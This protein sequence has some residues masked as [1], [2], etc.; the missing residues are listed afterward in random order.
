MTDS[1]LAVGISGSPSPTSKSRLLVERVLD[2][3]QE[4]DCGTELVDLSALPAE[5]LLAREEAAE[6]QAALDAVGK[7]NILVL[8]TPVYRATYT[9]LLKVFFDLMPP[10]YLAGKAAV[11]VATG[12][13]ADHALAVDHGLRPLVASLGGLGIAT[14]IYATPDDFD[15]DA[16]GAELVALLARAADEAARLVAS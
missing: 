16:P 9:G 5:A 10:D 14:G 15:D 6:V 4:R 3:L 13:S 8:G 7:A 2:L 12:G 11:L 1:P